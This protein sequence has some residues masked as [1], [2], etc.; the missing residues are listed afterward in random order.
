MSS[1]IFK[2]ETWLSFIGVVF[3]FLI[4]ILILPFSVGTAIPKKD[5]SFILMIDYGNGVEKKFQGSSK[6]KA[7]AWDALQQANAHSF[8]EVDA[9][10]DFYPASIDKNENGKNGKQW[11]LYVNKKRVFAPSSV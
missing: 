5:G 4:L 3:A 7:T 6:I 2:K 11:I 10:L 1:Y 8:L 9:A